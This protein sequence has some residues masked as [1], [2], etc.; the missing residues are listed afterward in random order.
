M[1]NEKFTQLQTMVCSGSV[2]PVV[3]RAIKYVS[4][5]EVGSTW[6]ILV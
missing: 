2:Q 5:S 3:N 4:R 6:S 1:V